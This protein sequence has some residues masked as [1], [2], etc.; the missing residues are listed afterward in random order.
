MLALKLRIR[1][2]CLLMPPTVTVVVPSY[3]DAPMLERCL[4]ALAD[5]TRPPDELLVVDNGSTD[6]TVE[7]A[8]RYG[9]RVVTE[10][11]R[12]IPQA[13]AAGLDAA[14]TEV[15]CRLDA[16]SLPPRNWVERIARAFEDASL[17]MLSGPGEYY[18]GGGFARWWGANVEMPMYYGPVAW[19]LGH[20]VVFGSNFAIRRSAWRDLRTR[21]HREDTI[22]HDDLDITLCLRPGTNVRFDPSLVVGVSARAFSSLP[23]AW[24]D[25]KRAFHTVGINRRELPLVAHRRAWRAA[26]RAAN[27]PARRPAH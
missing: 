5:Q 8:E 22:A 26:R 14:R 2:Q 10:V 15:I 25:W 18:D 19:F 21:V 23:R 13:T 17:D 16:D 24:R 1:L 11:K 3:N 20:D 6:T 12:G 7:V 9:A 27:S 4:A